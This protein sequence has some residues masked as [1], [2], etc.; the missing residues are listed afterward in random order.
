MV[1][2]TKERK[3]YFLILFSL[4][5]YIIILFCS[6]LTIKN[7]LF[8]FILYSLI[9]IIFSTAD[10]HGKDNKNIVSY[11]TLFFIL[12]FLI[13]LFYTLSPDT[14]YPGEYNMAQGIL[15]V[16]TM[17]CF[18]ILIYIFYKQRNRIDFILLTMIIYICLIPFSFSLNF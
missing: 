18:A 15:A 17:I 7:I 1:Y 6:K 2:Y 13:M 8:P 10:N 14:N 9:V 4:I 3:L 12:L 11:I 16:I 5:F